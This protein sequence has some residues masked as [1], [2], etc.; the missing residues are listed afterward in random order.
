MLFGARDYDPALGRWVAKDPIGF[1][2]GDVSLYGYC[3]GDPVGL[4]DPSGTSGI[5]WF[6][7][8]GVTVSGTGIEIL[9]ATS[10]TFPVLG[11]VIAGSFIGIG[12]LQTGQAWNYA[13]KANEDWFQKRR[14]LACRASA[15]I[16]RLYAEGKYD[17]AEH[18][19]RVWQTTDTEL[20]LAQAEDSKFWTYSMFKSA[21]DTI[22][23]L[24][25]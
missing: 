25:R 18:L 7:V 6:T 4:V 17:E 11:Q 16:E 22:L 8:G 9:G 24:A 3:L 20:K 10:L 15:G 14:T 12:V 2:G 1:A 13:S 21:W 19:R 5:P 23:N